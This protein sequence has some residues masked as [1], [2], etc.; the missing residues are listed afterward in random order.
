M[1]TNGTGNNR[2]IDL[3]SRL[4]DALIKTAKTL[5]EWEMA[6]TFL[7]PSAIAQYR[8]ELAS[9]P[10]FGETVES[11]RAKLRTVD[12]GYT[13]VRLGNIAQE[14]GFGEAFLRLATAILAEVAIPFQP[15]LRWPLWKEI[16]TN[17]AASP[18]MSTG[19]GY[20]AFHMDLVNATMPPDYSVLLCVRPD[21]LGAGASILSDARAATARL[22]PSSRALLAD[23]VY[24]YG[25]FFEL[26]DVGEEYRPF[27]VL[28][29][30]PDARGFIRFT[31]KML[32]G[33]IDL[34]ADHIRAA[35]DLADQ[36]IAG[37]LSFILQR[38]DFLIVNQ[39]KWLHGREPLASGQHDVAPEERRLLLQLFMR[40][41]SA[42]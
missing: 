1:S 32:T 40:D 35:K 22:T 33:E 6:G 14:L 37:Q 5:P 39:H 34:T 20:N 19:I 27:P 11:L 8:A 38:G 24:R 30:E 4:E 9:V 41:A 23:V 3:P 42:V 7:A 21:P 13:V 17:L 36:L 26:S 25:S 18:G 31:A 12:T 29:G 15:F 16:G 10:Q 2:F 28:D